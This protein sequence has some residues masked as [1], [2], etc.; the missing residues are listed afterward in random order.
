MHCFAKS[1]RPSVLT[2]YVPSSRK[3]SNSILKVTKY[4]G[5]WVSERLMAY[6]IGYEFTE[7]TK[8]GYYTE[9]LP[10]LNAGRCEL[11]DG[12][13]LINQLSSLE[14]RAIRGSNR[15]SID[16]PSGM[17]DGLANAAAI[18]LVLASGSAASLETWARLGM[19]PMEFAADQAGM[20][21]ADFMRARKGEPLPRGYIPIG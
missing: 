6:G 17:N 18:A 1:F 16:H 13:R 21:L 10:I 19:S 14:R 9:A 3:L 5:T 11:L 7:R 20:S 8:S 15:D 2:K 12:K 4:S